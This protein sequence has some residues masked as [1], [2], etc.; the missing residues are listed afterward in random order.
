MVSAEQKY[1]RLT[2]EVKTY[3]GAVVAFSGGVDSALLL[4][5]ARDALGGRALAATLVSQLLLPQELERARRVARELGVEHRELI[6]DLLAI[7]EVGG[8]SDDRCFHCKHVILSSLLELAQAKGHGIVLEGSHC[9]DAG[10]YRPGR[11]AVRALGV[12]SPLQTHGFTKSDIRR[13]SCQLG[14]ETWKKPSLPCLATRFPYGSRITP[15]RLHQVRRGEEELG[16]LGFSSLRLRHHGAIARL[17]VGSGELERALIQR[18]AIIEVLK[19]AG[20]TY[21]ALDLEGYRS[22]SMDEVREQSH[23]E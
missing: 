21:V 23:C 20:F 3:D 17:E 7:P 16:Q 10:E 22:G 2:E 1:R 6:V 9:S 14:L 19:R 18:H 13:L 8:N 11:Q 4:R 5:A 15:G 12:L